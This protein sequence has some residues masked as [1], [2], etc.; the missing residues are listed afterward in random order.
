MS[1]CAYCPNLCQENQR[2][3]VPD[4][5]IAAADSRQ[6]KVFAE[7][8]FRSFGRFPERWIERNYGYDY[9][10]LNCVCFC[11]CMITSTAILNYVHPLRTPVN[12]NQS[13]AFINVTYTRYVMPLRTPSYAHPMTS[14]IVVITSQPITYWPNHNVRTP[15]PYTLVPKPRTYIVRTPY[16]VM[17]TSAS[18]AILNT[19]YFRPRRAKI[20]HLFCFY[21]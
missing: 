21:R 10:K 7:T 18:A 20:R 1:H 12:L 13:H 8:A 2:N 19:Y 15:R 5:A 17:L 4:K 6:E 14:T 9:E 3:K 16:D 11:S